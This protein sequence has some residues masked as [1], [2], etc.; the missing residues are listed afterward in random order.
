MKNTNYYDT[1]L[2]L[3]ED[4]KLQYLFA[5][6]GKETIIKAIQYSPIISQNGRTLYNLGFGDYDETTQDIVDDSNSNNGD[7]YTVFNTVLNS[8]PDF[9]STNPDGILYVAGSDSSEEYRQNCLQ[10]CKK[11]LKCTEVCRKEDRRIKTY[12]NYVDKNFETLSTEYIFFG[13]NKTIHEKF[14]QYV[15]WQEY[16]EIMVY[17][18]K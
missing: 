18:I 14:V 1:E 4:Q 3:N 15:P 5:S 17:K 10:T 13:R 12:C 16:H 8:V 6:V 7:M 11:P 2:T 9:F